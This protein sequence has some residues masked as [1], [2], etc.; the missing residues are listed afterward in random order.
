[1]NTFIETFDE[2][3][4][5]DNNVTFKAVAQNLDWSKDSNAKA[6]ADHCANQNLSGAEEVIAFLYYHYNNDATKFEEIIN[7]MH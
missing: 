3:E 6:F 1:M 2:G 5:K 4:G 7:L